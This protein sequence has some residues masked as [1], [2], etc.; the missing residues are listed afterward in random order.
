V[1]AATSGAIMLCPEINQTFQS[2]KSVIKESCPAA[3]QAAVALIAAFFALQCAFTAQRH[4]RTQI[5]RSVFS[6]RLINLQSESHQ[7]E[8][9]YSYTRMR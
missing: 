7:V 3:A 4:A 9:M 2:N 5:H 6:H 8:R 1:A